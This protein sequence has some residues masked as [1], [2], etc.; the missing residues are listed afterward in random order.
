MLAHAATKNG[1]LFSIKYSDF[2]LF[3]TYKDFTNLQPAEIY[4]YFNRMW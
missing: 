2:S 4:M 3:R 1:Q